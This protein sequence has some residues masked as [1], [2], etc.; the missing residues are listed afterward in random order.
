MNIT[1][2]VSDFLLAYSEALDHICPEVVDHHK[3]VAYWAG[4]LAEQIGFDRTHQERLVQAA[5]LHDIGIFSLKGRRESLSFEFEMEKTHAV[6]GAML[7]QAAPY[8]V[9]HARIIRHHHDDYEADPTDQTVPL[10]SR[11]IFLVDRIAVMI[12]KEKPLLIQRQEIRKMLQEQRGRKF[13]PKVVDAFSGIL[14]RE[15]LWLDLKHRRDQRILDFLGNTPLIMEDEEMDGFARLFIM[16]IDFRSRFTA[17]H[18]MAVAHVVHRL[19]EYAGYPEEQRQMIKIAGYFHDIG[20]VVVPAEIL[21]K[22]QVLTLDEAEIMR[23][24]PYH[25]HRI[26]HALKGLGRYADVAAQHHERSDGT[27]Y[28]YHLTYPSLEPESGMLA[29]ADI[30]S[31][32]TENRSYRPSMPKEKVLEILGYYAKTRALDPELILHI[33]EHFD[34]LQQEVLHIHETFFRQY[35]AFDRIVQKCST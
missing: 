11:I 15:N 20:K 23:E 28:P 8:F 17:A 13:S 2:N 1:L 33:T 27:G 24:H 31:A 29:I 35:D 12:D 19:S 4:V 25:T 30:F 14:N 5:L 16:A 10:E 26:L 21:D 34:T 32:V 9:E 7:L 3:D 6:A 22:P 18:S